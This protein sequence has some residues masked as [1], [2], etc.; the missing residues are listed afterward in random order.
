[1]SREFSKVPA[2]SYNF[3]YQEKKMFSYTWRPA[4]GHLYVVSEIGVKRAVDR[5]FFHQYV[6]MSFVLRY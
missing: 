4:G 6:D 2:G 5:L 3:F 1:M